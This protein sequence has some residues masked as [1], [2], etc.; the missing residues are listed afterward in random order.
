[1]L[2]HLEAVARDPDF[3][4]PR[5]TLGPVIAGGGMGV[6]YRA[7]DRLLDRDVAIKL[8]PAVGSDPVLGTRLEQEARI[9]ARLDHPGLVPVHDLGR[10]ADGRAYYVMRLVEGE[11]L[12][13]NLAVTP[14]LPERLRLFLRIL[15]PVAFA[16]AKGIVHRDLK[17]ANIMVG[18]FGEVLVLDWGI[19]KLR[20]PAQDPPPTTGAT[21]P[22]V[23]GAGAV[24]GTAGFM[25]PEQAL[26]RSATVDERADVYA[27]GAI[28]R[29]LLRGHPSPPRPLLAIRDRAMAVAPES[30]YASVQALAA[31]V[32]RFLN[33][34]VVE[35]YRESPLERVGRFLARHRIAVTL[36][37]AYLV[38]RLALLLLARR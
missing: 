26:G 1:M 30:R 19:A 6:V 12:D 10:L 15:E 32:S 28:L 35:A 20:G 16:H 24:L 23:T 27:L 2:T 9:L 21:G 8:V 5:Y 4:H 22:G 31:E 33:G 34:Q 17:P 36:I 11:R 38:M 29:D 3:E 14:S 37:L 7:R 25:A 18:P 13:Q